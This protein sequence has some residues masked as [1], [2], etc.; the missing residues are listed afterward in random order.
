MTAINN[1]INIEDAKPHI[2]IQGMNA[3][4]VVPLSLIGDIALGVI[5]LSDVEGVDDFVPT[6]LLE[7][8]NMEAT[9]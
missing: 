2:T 6:L 1:V 4:H 5:A 7:W 9:K 3:V 8:L